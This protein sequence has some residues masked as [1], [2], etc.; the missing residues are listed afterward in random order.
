MQADKN[1]R[2][3]AEEANE[4][5]PDDADLNWAATDKV[6][7]YGIEK[8]GMLYVTDGTNVAPNP[9]CIGGECLASSSHEFFSSWSCMNFIGCPV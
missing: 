4:L 8:N 2:T 7:M 6:L 3:V 9:S 5:I 1:L